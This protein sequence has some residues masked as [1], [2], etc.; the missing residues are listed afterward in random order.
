MSPSKK[1]KVDEEVVKQNFF[2]KTAHKQITEF[3]K[4]VIV[5]GR[6]DGWNHRDLAKLTGRSKTTVGD[7]L[8]R[9]DETGEF[10]REEGSGRKRKI[11][12]TD[13][14]YAEIYMKRHRHCTVDEIRERC[15][16]RHVHRSTISRALA[17]RGLM[18]S[19]W[20]RRKPFVSLRNRTKRLKFA[21]E[22][23]H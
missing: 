12:D 17:R 15:G 14:D 2:L 3:E 7:V 6:N 10:G 19:V 1:S 16:L 8:K 23:L 22:H 4:G 5:Q 18:T 11:S 9:Y 20:Q 21:R 13:V